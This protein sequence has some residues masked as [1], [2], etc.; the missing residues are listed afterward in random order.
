MAKRRSLDTLG[1]AAQA[2]ETITKESAPDSGAEEMLTTA[3]H[4]P[5]RPGSCCAPSPS[6]CAAASSWRRMKG[7]RR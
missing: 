6:P 4:I 2:K 7:D 3:I 1:V 5:R